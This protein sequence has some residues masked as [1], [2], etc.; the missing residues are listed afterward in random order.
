MLTSVRDGRRV[1]AVDIDT[2]SSI[3]KR[4]YTCDPSRAPIIMDE[5]GGAL[6][7]ELATRQKKETPF[8]EDSMADIV[9]SLSEVGWGQFV[10]DSDVLKAFTSHKSD[11]VNFRIKGCAFNKLR[12]GGETPLCHFT[13]GLLKGTMSVLEG[14]QFRAWEELCTSKGDDV[15]EV[16]VARR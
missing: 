16:V 14:E 8:T 10:F 13:V 7:A 2:W 11:Q 4:I 15:C 12:L 1:V 6:G 3:C 5:I 9:A